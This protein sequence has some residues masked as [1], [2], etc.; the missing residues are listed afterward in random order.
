MLYYSIPVA[1]CDQKYLMFQ[2]AGQLYTFFCL[3]NGLTSAPRL[4][5]KILKPVFAALHKEGYDIMGY[6]DD[7]ILIGDNYDECK[8]AVLKAVNLFQTP[9]KF[10][11]HNTAALHSESH[12]FL[13][14]PEKS[15]LTPKQKTDFLGFTINSKNMTLQLTKQKR[16][17]IIE[18]F[19]LTLKHANN[20]TIWEF[21]KILGML[22]AAILGVKYGRLHL[23]YSIK[24]KNQALILSKDSYDYYFKLSKV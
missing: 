1:T 22:K 18:N 19:D 17:K 3:P 23:F 10:T 7:S 6:L 11:A 2:F 5:T 20:I 8:A 14:H 16:N 12:G 15:S 24:C 4:F 21:F 13:V 9:N